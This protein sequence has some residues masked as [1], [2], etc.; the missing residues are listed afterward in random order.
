MAEPG[1]WE[2]D[3]SVLMALLTRTLQVGGI[4]RG[5]RIVRSPDVVD[6]V[7]IETDRLVTLCGIVLAPEKVHRATV[8][9]VQVGLKN[10]RGD[11]ILLHERLVSVT[12]PT[13]CQAV[14]PV[15][16]IAGAADAVYPVALDASRYVSV[17]FSLQCRSVHTGAIGRVGRFVAVG[18][19]LRDLIA[20]LAAQ[21]NDLMTSM[22]VHT[23]R[24]VAIST[25][26]DPDMSA[27]NCYLK[28]M[29]VAGTTGFVDG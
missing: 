18:A 4:Y 27:I 23:Y 28:L 20:P 6:S 14:V 29:R 24:S 5:Q 22:A 21:T 1:A 2:S 16:R 26:K 12:V 8:K 25:F 10:I 19:H 15:R 17:G 13:N 7:T 11:A 3:G 9:V